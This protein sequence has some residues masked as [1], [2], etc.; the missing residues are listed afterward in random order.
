VGSGYE[1]HAKIAGIVVVSEC[2]RGFPDDY[3][4]FTANEPVDRMPRLAGIMQPRLAG[5]R[6]RQG[7]GS[8]MED[9]MKSALT[10]GSVVL[11][12]FVA[13]CYR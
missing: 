6:Q 5:I 12:V 1:V 10:K 4:P 7:K 13:L 3:L 8:D 2:R 9:R 11:L